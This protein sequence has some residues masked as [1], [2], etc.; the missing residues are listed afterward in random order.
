LI[1]YPDLGHIFYPSSKWSTGIG[2]IEPYVLAD[3]YAW[4]ESHSGFTKPATTAVLPS[5]YSSSSSSTN[6]TK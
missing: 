2:P 1:T 5:S 6:S 4:L 3:L